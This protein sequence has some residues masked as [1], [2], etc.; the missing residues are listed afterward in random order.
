[1]DIQCPSNVD[2]M[3]F[4]WSRMSVKVERLA[5]VGEMP[6]WEAWVRASRVASAGPA[7]R[8]LDLLDASETEASLTG[9]GCHPV[10]GSD[11]RMGS[12]QAIMTEPSR[13]HA[14]RSP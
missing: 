14:S 2:V 7:R 13:A 8:K 12:C 11:G 4:R 1:M 3:T 5:Q 9:W 6:G 10:R